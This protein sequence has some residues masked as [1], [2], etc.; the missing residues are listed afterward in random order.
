MYL[1]ENT[2]GQ[3]ISPASVTMTIVMNFMLKNGAL[4]EG[5]EPVVFR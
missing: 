5:T 1:F 4:R 2:T 3:V